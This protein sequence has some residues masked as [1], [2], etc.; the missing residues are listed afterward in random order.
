MMFTDTSAARPSSSSTSTP[1]WPGLVPRPA[2]QRPAGLQA[3]RQ[4]ELQHS[5]RRQ[6]RRWLR[7]GDPGDHGPADGLEPGAAGIPQRLRPTSWCSTT[8]T[9]TTASP[10]TGPQPK[11]TVVIE[12]CVVDIPG[13]NSKEE[14]CTFTETITRCNL[15]L[16]SQVSEKMA[17][18]IRV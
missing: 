17:G 12:P 13:D 10:T 6:H 18:A 11:R 16:L 5:G 14:T 4:E 3:I 2:V 8:S 1:R 7:L 9:G 15:Q